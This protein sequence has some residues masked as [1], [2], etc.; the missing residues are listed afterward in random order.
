M[1]PSATSDVLYSTL[2]ADPT[3][4]SD[5]LGQCAAARGRLHRLRGAVAAV[6]GLVQPR[7]LTFLVLLV[8]AGAAL[9]QLSAAA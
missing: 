1:V 4:L 5:H 9:V 6:D 8:L 7:F 2:P 3:R